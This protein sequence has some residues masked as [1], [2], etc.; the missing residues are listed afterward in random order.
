MVKTRY[1]VSRATT[2]VV[3]IS[4]AVPNVAGFQT[5]L[6]FVSNGIQ[7]DGGLLSW[8]LSPVSSSSCLFQAR[9]DDITGNQKRAKA[10]FEYQE[11]KIQLNAM[12][13]QGVSS[14]Q[15][16]QDKKLELEQYVQRVVRNRPS[17]ISLKDLNQNLPG[18]KWRLAFSTESVSKQLPADATVV[19]DFGEPSKLDYCLQF[20]KKTL[21]LNRLVAK[22]SYT[23][24]SG[25]VNPGLVTFVYDEI[26]TD[27]FGLKNIGVGFFGLLKGRS[28]YIQTQ[29]FDGNIWIDGGIEPSP[30]GGIGQE[31]FNV[32]MLVQE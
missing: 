14:S 12:E 11:L 23:V 10:D 30:D 22:S 17:S 13:K 15:L 7:S 32:Y 2:V 24:D 3:A 25:L 1:F 20:G 27:V 8:A 16:Q 19:L 31:Y 18:T 4:T 6:P 29:Y 21:G 9:R 5:S 28:N 26:S